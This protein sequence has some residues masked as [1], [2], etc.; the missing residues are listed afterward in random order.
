MPCSYLSNDSLGK[1][2][3]RKQ[4]PS[5]VVEADCL[6]NEQLLNLLMPGQCPLMPRI[7]L[8][9]SV[10]AHLCLLKEKQLNVISDIA[11]FY[12]EFMV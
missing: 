6:P 5:P 11:A 3:L 7:N 4:L 9:Q 2:R 12:I 8:E 1:L 10:T